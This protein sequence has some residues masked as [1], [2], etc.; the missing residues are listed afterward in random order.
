MVESTPMV[1]MEFVLS[2]LRA[3]EMTASPLALINE[4][5]AIRLA[6]LE[7]QILM[8]IEKAILKDV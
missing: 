6:M 3:K 5:A 1:S 7:W 4:K 8:D 2:W